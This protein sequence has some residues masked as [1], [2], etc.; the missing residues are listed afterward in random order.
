M[1]GGSGT[2]SIQVLKWLNTQGIPLVILDFQGQ[3]DAS[4]C[5][6]SGITDYE[7]GRA[8]IVATHP[9][10]SLLIAKSL[11]TRKVRKSLENISG[12]EPT[13]DR[14]ASA[15]KLIEHLDKLDQA[16]D[17]NR[18]LTLEATAALSYFKAWQGEPLKWKVRKAIPDYWLT[19]GRRESP[20][21]NTNRHAAH[22]VNAILNYGYAVLESQV[23][24]ALG[25]YGFDFNVSYLHARQHRRDSLV[26]DLMEPLRPVLDARLFD[27]ALSTEFT[28]GDFSLT[29]QGACRL[30]PELSRRIAQLNVPDPEVQSVV[31]DFRDYLLNRVN[32]V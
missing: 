10:E 30:N 25:I 13:K 11:V 22:P 15:K 2:V 3:E 26:Y 21:S 12:L 23:R 20:V 9:E 14:T 27:F 5:T 18:L 24:I 8:Q 7:L 17:I 29:S 32:S 31:S 1:L 6:N 28:D 4:V 16:K 19:V